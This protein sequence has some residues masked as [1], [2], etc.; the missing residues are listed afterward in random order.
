MPQAGPAP[1]RGRAAKYKSQRV[2]GRGAFGTAF[3]VRNQA[4]SRLYVMKRL[5]LE[6]MSKKERDDALNECTVMMK[7]RR[8][9]NIIRVHEY[10][11]E[12]NRLNI[13]MDYADGGDLAQRIEAQAASKT[14]FAEGQV[15]NWFVQICLALKHAHDRKVLHRDLKPQNVFLTRMSLV[16]NATPLRTASTWRAAPHKPLS[17]IPSPRTSRPACV[18]ECFRCLY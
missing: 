13:V 1:P 3:L 14:L 7:L 6:H 18:R 12:A 17:H 9:P 8:H 2:I 5:T 4:D 11:E 10:F 16:R 15:L